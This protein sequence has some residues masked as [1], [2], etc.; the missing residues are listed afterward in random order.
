MVTTKAAVPRPHPASKLLLRPT[1]QDVAKHAGVARST[2]SAILAN[3]SHCYAAKETRQRV[4]DAAQKL[5]YQPNALSRALLG[6]QTYTIGLILRSLVGP[7]LKVEN[8]ARIEQLA[9]EEGYRLLVAAHEH[10]PQ[11]EQNLIRS[12]LGQHVDGFIVEMAYGDANQ[13]LYARL[14]E[15]R[16]PLVAVDPPVPVEADQVAVDREE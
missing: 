6:Q 1:L 3:K 5:N 12:Y 7:T 8:I 14:L 10:K 4:F 16:M 11:R 2:V 9:Q 15:E 13:P